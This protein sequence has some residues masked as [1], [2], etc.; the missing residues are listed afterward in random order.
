VIAARIDH[1]AEPALDQ[2]EVLSVLAE[3]RRG[4]RLSSKSRRLAFR[5]GF[6]CRGQVCG[7]ERAKANPMRFWARATIR[8]PL[9]FAKMVPAVKRG[10]SAAC[11]RE[12][13]AEQAVALEA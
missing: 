6:A 8:L 4:A 9:S 13:V 2:R 12:R 10:D 1:D 3:Q 7:W 11:A 5:A